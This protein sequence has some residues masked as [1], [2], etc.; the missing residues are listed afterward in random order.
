MKRP[1]RKYDSTIE[2]LWKKEI[3]DKLDSVHQPLQ[4][5]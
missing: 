4:F 5:Y 1:L 3:T 2:N